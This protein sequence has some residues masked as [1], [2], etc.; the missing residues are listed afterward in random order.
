MILYLKNPIVSA[1]QLLQLKNNFSKV[2]GY[3]INVQKSLLFLYTDSS[4]VK[5]QIK[6]ATIFTNVTKIIKYPGIWLIREL[7]VLYKKN[8]KTLFK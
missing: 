1:P 2:S 5:S 7:K 6:N 3:K 4:Q 8:Y